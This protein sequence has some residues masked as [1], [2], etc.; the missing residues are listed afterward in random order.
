MNRSPI[1]SRTL[2]DSKSKSLSSSR[3]V[4]NGRS[5]DEL[6]GFKLYSFLILKSY[7][8][9]LTRPSFHSNFS[10]E[11]YVSSF[12]VL[13]CEVEEMDILKDHPDFPTTLETIKVV[14][15][16][17]ISDQEFR[18]TSRTGDPS[19]YSPD[20]FMLCTDCSLGQS[21]VCSFPSFIYET[22]RVSNERCLSKLFSSSLDLPPPPPLVPDQKGRRPLQ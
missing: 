3:E 6:R 7:V 15:L 1:G 13:F 18:R 20:Y 2:V 16:G 5:M 10:P 11:Y 8:L 14:S 17:R 9:Y 12:L 21:L 4:L 19:N 22:R